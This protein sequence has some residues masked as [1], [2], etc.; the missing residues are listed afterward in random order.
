MKKKVLITGT[1]SGFGNLTAKTLLKNGHTV[2]AAMRDPNSRNKEPAEE[3]KKLGAHIIHLDVTNTKSVTE[4][5]AHA[6]DYAEGIDT[7]VNNAGIGV[8]GLQEMFS[9]D[10]FKK[11]FDI[12]VF[13]VQ[14]V[15]R[16]VLPYMRKNNDGL[17][18]QISSILGRI[19]LPFFG[20]YNASK[21]AVEALAENYRVELSGFG[22]DSVIVEPGAFGTNFPN[23]I[24]HPS[25]TTR[26]HSYGAMAEAPKIQM[27]NFAKTFEG[28]NPP[29]PQRVADA[30]LK[31]IQTPKGE[32]PFRTV[33]DDLGM[34]PSIDIY[35]EA[36]EKTTQGIYESMGMSEM[37]KIRNRQ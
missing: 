1:N 3:L 21:Y 29:N 7:V 13:G 31:L 16:A 35:N 23:R 5:V 30:I 22:I 6:V 4:G 10:D 12:N 19:S 28:P 37:L 2:V 14:R 15:N 32:R 9:T 26:N 8:L 25:D 34:T 24:L 17:L 27:E 20:P 36:A 33:V 11:L 18:I